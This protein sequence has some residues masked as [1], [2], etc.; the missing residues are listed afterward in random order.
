MSVNRI[1][2]ELQSTTFIFNLKRKLTLGNCFDKNKFLNLFSGIAFKSFWL[3]LTE[4]LFVF[5]SISLALSNW[6][7]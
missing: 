5:N 1:N 6:V 3:H 7:T 4:G 2:L